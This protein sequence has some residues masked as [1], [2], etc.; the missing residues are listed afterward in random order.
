M[1]RLV[2]LI[3]LVYMLY[4]ILKPK[5]RVEKP[6]QGPT[7]IPEEDV[8]VRDPCCKAYIPK[9]QALEERVAEEMLYFCSTECRD[10]YLAGED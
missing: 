9:S 4:R 6:R 1:I 7:H 3:A 2:I 5:R 10:S 8:M